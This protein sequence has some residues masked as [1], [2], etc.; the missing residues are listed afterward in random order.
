M[1]AEEHRRHTRVLIDLRVLAPAG[2]TCKTRH[3]R[4]ESGRE[5]DQDGAGQ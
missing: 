4:S 5:A 2:G 3:L 1:F